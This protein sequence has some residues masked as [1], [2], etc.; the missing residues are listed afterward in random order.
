MNYENNNEIENA[1]KVTLE[2]SAD[3]LAMMKEFYSEAEAEND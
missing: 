3:Y 2:Q 1:W